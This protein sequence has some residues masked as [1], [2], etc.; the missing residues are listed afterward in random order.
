[1]IRIIDHTK[2]PWGDTMDGGVRM[3][4][5]GVGS[6]LLQGAGEILGGMA[7]L[8]GDRETGIQ[9]IRETCTPLR[10]LG[11]EPVHVMDGEIRLIGRRRIIA[12][13]DIKDVIGDILFDDKPGAT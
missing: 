13:R 1:M 5:K 11:G 3:D 2:L 7:D 10:G 8:E 9:G 4:D 6:G 12:M